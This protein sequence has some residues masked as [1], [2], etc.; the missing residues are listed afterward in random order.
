MKTFV[1]LALV[2]ACASSIAC[3]QT[4]PTGSASSTVQAEEAV[5]YGTIVGKWQFVY[6]DARRK[7]VESEL[8]QQIS[9]PSKLAQAKKEAEEEAASSEIEFTADHTYISRIGSEEILRDT[10]SVQNGTD[11]HS[12]VMTR[13]SWL[14]RVGLGSITVKVVDKDAIVMVDPKKGDLLFKRA[15]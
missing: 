4:A 8:E 1:T 9:D 5:S 14:K 3:S 15:K 2:V 6:D 13:T 12:L 10:F 7:A 11:G